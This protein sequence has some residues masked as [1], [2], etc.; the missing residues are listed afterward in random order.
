MEMDGQTLGDRMKT[1]EK[2]LERRLNEGESFIIRL[3]GHSFSK[4][5]KGMQQPWDSRF[6]T[7]MALTARDILMQYH[8]KGVYTQS[9]EI[10]VIFQPI[11]SKANPDQWEPW[12][13][14][15]RIQKLI[16]VL[17]GYASARFNYHLQKLFSSQ[18]YESEME[19]TV[20][21]PTE[22]ENSYCLPLR[23]V[24]NEKV[25]SD[26]KVERII[27]GS[28]HFDARCIQFDQS[29]EIQN[30][31]L[32]RVR[33][34]YKNA[35]SKTAQDLIG[36]KKCF[37]QNTGQKEKLIELASPGALKRIHPSILH[38]TF[39][40]KELYT[41]DNPEKSIRSRAAFIVDPAM[42][43]FLRRLQPIKTK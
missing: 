26:V 27:S 12:I 39:V 41:L 1:Y 5:T 4:F 31:I 40:F 21:S 35:I 25:L 42:V 2:K 34:C 14:N 7:A 10:S 18:K 15:G 28:A 16:S 11:R 17:A 33:D 9:D 24:H 19:T 38:G 3:D 6:C 37:K 36:A 20:F 43:E 8:A 30:N 32:W 23:D 29:Y 22:D 13:F